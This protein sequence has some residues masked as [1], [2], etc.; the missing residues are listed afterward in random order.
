M[1]YNGRRISFYAFGFSSAENLSAQ[2]MVYLGATLTQVFTGVRGRSERVSQR[3][4][5]SP[6]GKRDYIVRVTS[7]TGSARRIWGI[8]K[9]L[10]ALSPREKTVD[11]CLLT[12][13][14]GRSHTR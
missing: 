14:L 5:N 8:L 3:C 11:F 9:K 13:A 12:E 1:S 6:D 10:V 7:R 4:H 2:C